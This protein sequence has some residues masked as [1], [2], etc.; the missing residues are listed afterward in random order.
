MLDKNV[1][2]KAITRK[3]NII[4]LWFRTLSKFNGQ[5]VTQIDKISAQN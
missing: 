2:T 1:K 3:E 5:L 4:E